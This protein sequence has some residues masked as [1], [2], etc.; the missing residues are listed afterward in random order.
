MG[1]REGLRNRGSTRG[2]NF[3][4][5]G[6]GGLGSRPQSVLPAANALGGQFGVR[7]SG[8]VHRN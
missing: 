6:V 2:F 7:E 3:G 4:Y 1:F 5:L 8:T